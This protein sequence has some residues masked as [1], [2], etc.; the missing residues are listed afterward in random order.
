MYPKELKNVKGPETKRLENYW[1]RYFLKVFS[2]SI[3]F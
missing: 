3:I 2:S 1:L